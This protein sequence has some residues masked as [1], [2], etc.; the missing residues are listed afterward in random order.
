MHRPPLF[1]L[2]ILLGITIIFSAC[3][4][5]IEEE[6]PEIS[7]VLI[8][9]EGNFNAGDGSLSFY[10]EEGMTVTNNIVADANAGNEIGSTVQ[11]MYMHDGVGYVI[12]N[13]SDKIEFISTEDYTY[14]ANPITNISQPRFM[15]VV[16]EM[17][18]VSCWGPW[19]Q[20]W[21]LP[22]SYIAVIDLD[23][24]TVVDTLEC[25]SGPEGIISFGN[26]LFV[27]NSYE[28][29]FSVID[30]ADNSHLKLELDSSPFHFA[31]DGSGSLWITK[32]SGLQNND[33]VSLDSITH[34]SVTNMNGKMT[35][36][37]DGEN[38]YF[39]T[40]ESWPGTATEIFSFDIGAKALS[41]A[42]L[43][44]GENFYG[45]G[46]NPT[47]RKLYVSNSNAFS[48][49][50]EIFVYDAEGNLLDQQTVGVGPSSF[51]FN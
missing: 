44:S 31:L 29:S 33:P 34:I 28:F 36:D 10:D 22:D 19:S 4:E 21:A 25:G 5:N 1:F 43:V 8:V 47:T 48:G 3:N 6:M 24:R 12:C 49:P 30:L 16:G 15:T 18:Y 13:N 46:I 51:M 7:A 40:S 32:S 20:D 14:L 41:P 35:I 39:L 26:K 50:G 9:N 11:S 42:P 27:A 2:F 45:L 17:G 23:D 38:I 37:G